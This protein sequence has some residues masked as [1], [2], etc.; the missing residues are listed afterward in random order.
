MTRLD[1]QQMK[2]EFKIGPTLILMSMP[3]ILAV[4]EV[5]GNIPVRMEMVVVFPAPLWPRKEV[6]WPS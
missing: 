3:L 5:G 1:I 4:P 6:I 2:S